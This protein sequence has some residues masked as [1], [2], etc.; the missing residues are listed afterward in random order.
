MN[1]PHPFGQPQHPS[2]SRVRSPE[3]HLRLFVQLDPELRPLLHG[4]TDVSGGSRKRPRRPTPHDATPDRV[5]TI[6]LVV[7]VAII[8]LLALIVCHHLDVL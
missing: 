2:F 8:P 5:R 7:W 1:A 6:A 4:Q 3:P